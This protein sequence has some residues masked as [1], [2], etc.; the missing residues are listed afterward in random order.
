LAWKTLLLVDD[1]EDTRMLL[2]HVLRRYGYDAVACSAA[3]APALASTTRTRIVVLD[4]G[5]PRAYDIAA[6]LRAEDRVMFI[7]A[8]TG[9]GE[10]RRQAA[11]QN[12]IDAYVRKPADVA[13]LIALLDD[14]SLHG[15]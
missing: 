4:V 14:V 2:A 6:E 1:N 13:K 10:Q 12:G 8:L 11:S 5:L 3:A 15:R 7:V 9:H